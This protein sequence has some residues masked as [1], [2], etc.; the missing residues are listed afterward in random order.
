MA[1]GYLPPTFAINGGGNSTQ[2]P[3]VTLSFSTPPNVSL[4]SITN[5]SASGSSTA[6]SSYQSVLPWNLCAGLA[7]C[8]PGAYSVTVR[9]LDAQN[10]T[11]GTV[12]H[13]IV[14]LPAAPSGTPQSSSTTIATSLSPSV[15]DLLQQIAALQAQLQSLVREA[16]AR[17]IAV[18]QTA[19]TSS[20]QFARD[21]KLGMTGTDVNELQLFLIRENTGPAA[22]KLAVHGTTKNFAALTLNAL[23]E[24]QKKAGIK[25]A[26]GYFG[27]IT[28]A[29]VKTL[30]Q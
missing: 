22:R 19:T 28:R 18:T 15:A 14:Y 30:M 3:S 8:P 2:S 1:A 9:F 20:F 13:S 12:S 6:T 25:P 29:Y 17:G 7:A 27:P 10:N 21:L 4:F 11:L 24:F 26:I 23:I 16:A 5:E